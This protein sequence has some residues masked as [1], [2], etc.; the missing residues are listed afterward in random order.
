MGGVISLRSEPKYETSFTLTLPMEIDKLSPVRESKRETIIAN[1]QSKS[2]TDLGHKTFKLSTLHNAIERQ[3]QIQENYLEQFEK[4]Q[5]KMEP[6]IK[7]KPADIE[8]SNNKII[9]AED[10]AINRQVLLKLLSHLGQTA[11]A[12]VD[13][14]ELVRA[15]DINKHKL[16]I[17]DMHMPNMNGLE[18]STILKKKYGDNIK[19][20]MLTADALTDFSTEQYMKTVDMV[21][22]KPCSKQKLKETI[23]TFL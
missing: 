15:F 4:T 11:D 9:V 23:D 10:N 6:Y 2:T 16:V 7:P 1:A 20:V 22:C 8:P 3:V 14:E 17:T 19:I 21:I 5:K 18:A 12:V 13:G